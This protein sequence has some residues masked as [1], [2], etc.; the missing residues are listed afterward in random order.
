M[1][2]TSREADPQIRAA[3]MAGEIISDDVAQ[4]IADGLKSPAEAD[5]PLC[6]LACGLDVDGAALVRRLDTLIGSPEFGDTDVLAELHALREWALCRVPHLVVE[7]YEISG[8]AW[9]AWLDECEKP[10]CVGMSPE[11]D[12][13]EGA[14]LV[15]TDVSLVVDA[16][17]N[18]S[19][20]VYPGEAR[21]PADADSYAAEDRD[22][23]GDGRWV[24]ASLLMG[25]AALLGGELSGFWAQS[26]GG[27][28][29]DPN[30]YWWQSDDISFL[31][32]GQAYAS[33]YQNPYSGEVQ[34][35]VARFGGLSDEQ[36]I[37]VYREWRG[38]RVTP[39]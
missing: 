6:A 21:Y 20:W 34:I 31:G 22:P 5:V 24:P 26:Y 28:P 13:P 14:R 7:E 9:S 2:L 25:A 8:D 18:L 16:C 12:R 36:L 17:D 4:T 39:R 30:P 37:K 3:L 27:D 38:E 32:V 10:R 19:C 1:I 33:R 35:K 15:D 11:R 23:N 29:F